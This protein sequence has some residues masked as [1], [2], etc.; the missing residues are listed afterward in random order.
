MG[1]TAVTPLRSWAS[2]PHSPDPAT[3][4]LDELCHAL[5]STGIVYPSTGLTLCYSIKFD[6]LPRINS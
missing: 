2:A 4:S 1:V 6:Q 5:Y 3:S